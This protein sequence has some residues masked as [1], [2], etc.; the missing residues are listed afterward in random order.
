MN[1]V[2]VGNHYQGTPS[3]TPRVPVRW[4]ERSLRFRRAVIA[5]LAALAVAATAAVWAVKYSFDHWNGW[6]IS[7]TNDCGFE[8]Y[9]DDGSDGL[10][11]SAGETISWGGASRSGDKMIR[12]WRYSDRL[13]EVKGL[14]V[15]LHGDSVLAGASCP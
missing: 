14:V 9:A 4:S 3:R 2:D 6:A 12:L 11:I 13:M 5:G 8:L 10:R 7:I 1:N 15:N